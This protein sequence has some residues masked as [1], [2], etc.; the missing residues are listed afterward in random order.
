[1]LQVIRLHFF[2]PSPVTHLLSL[3]HHHQ[4]TPISNLLST[5]MKLCHLVHFKTQTLRGNLQQGKS[6]PSSLYC[7]GCPKHGKDFHSLKF[8]IRVTLHREM[9][10]SSYNPVKFCRE[11]LNLHILLE[12]ISVNVIAKNIE[13]DY[14]LS[15]IKDLEGKKEYKRS[16]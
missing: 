8:L 11:S 4:N 16:G 9:Q 14:S 13:K 1:M 15:L 6:K 5:S 3:L 7:Q 2:L 10:N 12:W